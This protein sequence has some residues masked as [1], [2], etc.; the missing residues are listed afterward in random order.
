MSGTNFFLF[1]SQY[2]MVSALPIFIME[3]LGGGELEAGL[4][5]TSFQCGAVLCRP[6]AGKCIDAV[7]KRRL[8]FTAT[9]AFLLIM[10]GFSV[11]QTFTGLYVLR[12]AHGIVFAIGTTCAATLVALLLPAQK[13]GTGIGYFALSTNLAMVVGPFI[14]LILAQQFGSDV[15]FFFMIGLALLTVI[16]ANV[17]H[18]PH[19]DT[20]GA[21]HCFCFLRDWL[22]CVKP[23]FS[24]ACR[25][26]CMPGKERR[27]HCNVL[28]VSGYFRWFGRRSLR[29]RCKACRL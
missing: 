7:N 10:T 3:S 4:A 25:Q 9:V 26:K 2:I 17:C 1:M 29:D 20:D 18:Q 19:H 12:F 28:L 5:M 22:W 13:K 6:L 21:L 14:G 15:L 24:N 23:C 16:L 11:F 8:L 27:C